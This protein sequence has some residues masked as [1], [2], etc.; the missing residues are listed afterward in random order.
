MATKELVTLPWFREGL[1]GRAWSPALRVGPWLFVSGVTAVDYRTMRTVGA[2]GGT[3]TTPARLDPEAQWRQVLTN[4]REIVQAA[5]GTLDDVVLANV[6]VTDMQ[7]YVQYERIRREF[8]QPPYPVCTAVAVQRLV[9]P[10][11]VLEIEA[12]AYIEHAGRSAPVGPRRARRP[13]S[14]PV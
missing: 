11:W 6:Y 3:E 13:V 8:F 1:G 12:V 4:L 10:D 14:R 7:Y 9:H 5:G 2:T